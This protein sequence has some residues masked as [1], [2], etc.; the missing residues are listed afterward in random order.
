MRM[1]VLM[2]FDGLHSYDNRTQKKYIH[3]V[4][5]LFM[6]SKQRKSIVHLPHALKEAPRRKGYWRQI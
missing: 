5:S 6:C 3:Q 2:T 1:C 4:G